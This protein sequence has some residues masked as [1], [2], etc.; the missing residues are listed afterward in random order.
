[1]KFDALSALKILQ[2]KGQQFDWIYIDPPFDA[3]LYEDRAG[4]YFRL[5]FTQEC[6]AGGGRAS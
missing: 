5:Q 1:M 3:G 4:G 2:A 6:R